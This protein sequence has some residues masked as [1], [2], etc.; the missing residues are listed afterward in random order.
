MEYSD[1]FAHDRDNF[2][3]FRDFFNAQEYGR[4]QVGGGDILHEKGRICRSYK[5]LWCAQWKKVEDF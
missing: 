1:S 2:G 5:N 4:L 3:K